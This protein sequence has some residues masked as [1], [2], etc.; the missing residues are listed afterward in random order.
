MG[1][2]HRKTQRGHQHTSCNNENA[3]SVDAGADDLHDVAKVF[4]SCVL[5][6]KHADFQCRS[7]RTNLEIAASTFRVDFQGLDF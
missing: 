4:H 7:S 3:Y 1:A 5:A 6:G 2:T